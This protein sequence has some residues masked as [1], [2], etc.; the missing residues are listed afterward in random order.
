MNRALD[1]AEIRA[2][3]C[4]EVDS[5]LTL[6]MLSQV[7]RDWSDVSN[8]FLWR[9]LKSLVPMLQLMPAHAWRV[10][11][12]TPDKPAGVFRFRRPLKPLDWVPVLKRSVLVKIFKLDYH[13]V[14][15]TV[16]RIDKR[17]IEA[18]SLCPP[19]STLLPRLRCLHLYTHVNFCQRDIFFDVPLVSSVT[20][21]KVGVQSPS[22]ICFARIAAACPA[23]EWLNF[24]SYEHS[25][26]WA[27]EL[28]DSLLEWRTLTCVILEFGEWTL[29]FVLS[30]LAQLPALSDLTIRCNSFDNSQD[31]SILPPESFLSLQHL[32]L[33]GFNLSIADTILCSWSMRAIATITINPDLDGSSA[34]C[35]HTILR[36]QEHCDPLE[37]SVLNVDYQGW[38]LEGWPLRLEH[39]TPLSCFSRLVNVK[40][41]GPGESDIDDDACAQLARWWPYVE[42]L[43]I[44]THSRQ[45][46]RRPCTLMALIPFAKNCLYLKELTLPITAAIVPPIEPS[47]ELFKL[48]HHSLTYLGVGDAPIEKPTAVA[49]FLSVVFPDLDAVVYEEYESD[50]DD[51]NTFVDD[52]ERDSE[53]RGR[54]W[55][56]VSQS[57]P[58]MREKEMQTWN[59]G[60]AYYSSVL[61]GFGYDFSN[62]IGQL[63]V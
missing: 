62:L 26:M 52:R 38:I 12:S 8:I 17:V 4:G 39:I 10:V 29:A 11:G 30:S 1:I 3:I 21:L 42:T 5:L 43:S 31:E 7:S 35:R 20:K 55:D 34:D 28:G 45:L 63:I 36:I 48:R 19:P 25:P 18:I 54:R 58:M 50:T 53:E 57:L 13:G 15:S 6:R 46:D 33:G 37:L 32:T 22:S 41:C 16:P 60:L 49:L 9:S 27:P 23:L 14:S 61:P 24:T 59:M 2:A 51:D 40:I 47:I 56:I 44:G